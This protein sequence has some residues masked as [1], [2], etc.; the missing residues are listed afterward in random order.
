MTQDAFISYARATQL[1]PA[2][3]LRDA[4]AARGIAAFL[5]ERDI[6]R[7][8]PFPDALATVIADARSIVVLLDAAYLSRPWCVREYE[9]I[10]DGAELG[11]VVVALPGSS[12]EEILLHLPPS[13]ASRSWPQADDTE[14]LA[15]LIARRLRGDPA[16]APAARRAE[17]NPL[18]VD[19]A[20]SPRPLGG[21]GF[22][23]AAPR[24]LGSGFVGRADA[25]WRMFHR[26]ETL[27]ADGPP[28]AL[29]V[30]GAGGTGKTQLA[31]EYLHRY[32]PRVYSGGLVWLRA[33]VD[34]AAFEAQL[35]GALAAFRPD[36]G[37]AV[38]RLGGGA[39]RAAI[40]EA[41][42]GAAGPVLWVVDNIPGPGEPNTRPQSI[43]QYCPARDAVSLLCTSRSATVHG[44]GPALTVD[45]LPDDLAVDLLTRPEVQVGWLPLED[46]RAIAHW[47]GGLPL[48]LGVLHASMSEGALIASDLLARAR[49]DEP[50][51]VVDD[52]LDAIRETIPEG[53]LRGAAAAFRASYD[54]LS[55]T[56]ALAR[57]L[58]QIA[59]LSPIPVAES[60]LAT[61]APSRDL[62][63]LAR[64]GWLQSSVDEGPG[65]QRT[66]RLHRVAAS[67]VRCR[68]AN[69]P[70]APAALLDWLAARL[71]AGDDATALTPHFVVFG[72]RLGGMRC[73]DPTL[74]P[75]LTDA[76][77]RV[78]IAAATHHIADPAARG[79]RFIGAGWCA[80]FG[81]W[82]PLIA[83][84]R[85]LHA[86]GD[87]ATSLALPAML[88]PVGSV[89]DA[90]RLLCDL[91][92][93]PQH[94]V[95]WQALIHA[96]S[97]RADIVAVPA[98]RAALAE[99]NP[100]V[101]TNAIA[102]LGNIETPP[103]V[104]IDEAAAAL[105][106][107][108]AAVRHDAVTLLGHLLRRDV[109]A[110][111]LRHHLLT[112]ALVDTDDVATSAA[113]AL[114]CVHDDDTYRALSGALETASD[115]P[116]CERA[117]TVLAAYLHALDAPLPPRVE[118]VAEDGKPVIRAQLAKAPPRRPD[119][120][121]PLLVAGFHSGGAAATIA[122]RA[123]VTYLSGKLALADL[124][125]QLLARSLFADTI[126][127]A[128]TIEA[129]DSSFVSP[130]WW[131]AQAREALGDVSG[132]LADYQRVAT[133]EPRFEDAHVAVA[134]LRATTARPPS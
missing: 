12:A 44:L 9:A 119:L 132:A 88:Q 25:L 32:G 5:D 38:A 50:A 131:R 87:P 20:P 42:R 130:P 19:G 117:V 16:A 86:L 13:L 61:L 118:V 8:E 134:R 77:G 74:M 73:A 126:R 90:A 96:P 66:W 109:A 17:G 103:P 43:E 81:A 85:Q 60:L 58:D 101:R 105:T 76:I 63:A 95:R 79:L 45:A 23:S 47:A 100:N 124:A 54:V 92:A 97:F 64:R 41:V 110:A 71:A 33:D 34:D 72:E 127:L 3:A 122:Q 40:A 31:A 27:R 69:S 7:G 106:S 57:A 120:A 111:T 28:P 35:R 102:A 108:V 2:R 98:W 37:A 22:L 129:L 128:D 84:A 46:W 67:Y 51:A 78:A 99:P 82:E 6:G 52:E 15:D 80:R 10:I 93:D 1:R 83:R 21:P 121:F 55:A 113:K 30:S 29:L 112:R 48:V 4:L 36:L 62:A 133:L 68:S 91:L 59:L 107:E 39:L 49:T 65:A 26:L 114:G 56:P 53:T 116:A 94:D 14:A 11:R 89:P 18:L 104:L 115:D 75:A 123:L 24:T 125:Q 70:D